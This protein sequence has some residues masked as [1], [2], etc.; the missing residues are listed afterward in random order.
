MPKGGNGEEILRMSCSCSVGNPNVEA[1]RKGKGG[2]REEGRSAR[3][4][5]PSGDKARCISIHPE[6]VSK[7]QPV[8]SAV[9]GVSRR[10]PGWEE[11]TWRVALPMEEETRKGRYPNPKKPNLKG[12]WTCNTSYAKTSRANVCRTDWGKGGG[13]RV[14]KTSKETARCRPAHP[15]MVAL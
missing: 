2:E 9:K 15:A 13:A 12:G 11:L 14:Q 8:R 1:H 5:M 6:D 7:V 4:Q 3:G 10:G